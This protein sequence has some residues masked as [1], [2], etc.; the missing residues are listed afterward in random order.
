V[1]L[2]SKSLHSVFRFHSR[3]H[4]IFCCGSMTFCA[5]NQ[6]DLFRA[7]CAHIHPRCQPQAT[8]CYMK[9]GTIGLP[10]EITE[11][12][13]ITRSPR[14]SQTR[15]TGPRESLARLS[16]FLPISRRLPDPLQHDPTI[17]QRAEHTIGT[18]NYI[19]QSIDILFMN[20]FFCARCNTMNCMSSTALFRGNKIFCIEDEFTLSQTKY[21]TTE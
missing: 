12:T 8:S 7:D 4:I 18:A 13:H 20:P 10:K 17:N 21:P 14:V 11:R 19:A 15:S 3:L 2:L 1:L 5:Y 6:P 16:P 9:H